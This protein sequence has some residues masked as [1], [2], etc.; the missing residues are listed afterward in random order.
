M[1]GTKKNQYISDIVGDDYKLWESERIILN[2]GTGTGKTSFVLKT[3]VPYYL[4]Q[5]KKILYL[6]N[7]EKLYKQIK[8]EM[9]KLSGIVLMTYQ[10]LQKLLRK[11]YDYAYDLIIADECH[12]F[13]ADAKFNE[14]TDLAYEYVMSKKSSVIVLMSATANSFFDKLITSGEVKKENIYH[15]E[16]SYDYVEKVFMYTKNQ[17]TDIIDNILA[18]NEFD[19]ILVFVNSIQRLI[20]M[21]NYYGD[22]AYYM[23]SKSQ[24]CDF[25]TR[26]CIKN[27]QFN[28]RILFTTKVLD[29]GVDIIDTDLCHII[30]EIFDIDCTLQAIGRKRSVDSLDTCNFYFRLYDGRA[31]SNFLR[32]NKEQLAPVLMYLNDKAAFKNYLIEK[33]KNT[34]ELLRKNKIF[35]TDLNTEKL[36]VNMCVLK[37]YES[38]QNIIEDMKKTCYENVLFKNLGTDLLN[39]KS[40]LK[41]D[42]KSKDTFLCILESLQ[43]KKLF[44]EEQ[45]ELKEKFRD[46]LGLHDRTMGI[47]TLNGKLIDCNYKYVIESKQETSRKSE[48]YK[49][50]YWII[51]KI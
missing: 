10:R 31:I 21:Y 25:A 43:G 13:Y 44:K 47:N 48:F 42:N 20:E 11:G 14:Y 51:V 12:Y 37:K 6:C 2:S 46:I 36:K 34:R 7:R 22:S 40:K 1:I 24:E 45:Q 28:K 38:D 18:N 23:C 27:K 32:F 17:L 19:K 50:R 33:N 49:K 26:D 3:L 9:Q 8:P 4:K 39:K 15:I 16:K 29:N 41:I 30:S 5:N 35:C